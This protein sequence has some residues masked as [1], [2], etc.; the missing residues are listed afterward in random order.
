MNV[1]VIVPGSASSSSAQSKAL[2]SPSNYSVSSSSASSPSSSSNPAVNVRPS[3]AAQ[4]RPLL[5]FAVFVELF[6]L[7]FAGAS[8]FLAVTTDIH[9]PG[10][11]FEARHPSEEQ[12]AF[13]PTPLLTVFPMLIVLWFYAFRTLC[14]CRCRNQSGPQ[15]Y[16]QQDG[17]STGG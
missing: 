7:A 12:F 16:V 1:H 3:I 14:H 17:E 10:E 2:S 13:A 4:L 6:V 9:D 8:L 11:C 5:Y 15:Q